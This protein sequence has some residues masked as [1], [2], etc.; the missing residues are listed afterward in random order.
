[1]LLLEILTKLNTVGQL[2]KKKNFAFKMLKVSTAFHTQQC[3]LQRKVL[4]KK[5]R[6]FPGKKPTNKVVYSNY[7]G[8]KYTQTDYSTNLS[9]QIDNPVKFMENVQNAYKDGVQLFIEIGSEKVI[10]DIVKQNISD[11]S[12][13]VISF[14]G[15]SGKLSLQSFYATIAQLK[16]LDSPFNVSKYS[17]RD[18]TC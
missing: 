10:S 6:K 12:I 11:S 7:S 5:L 9:N 15:T 3:M 18:N 2:I 1:M 8:N 14:A 17:P 13:E 4:R 16:V